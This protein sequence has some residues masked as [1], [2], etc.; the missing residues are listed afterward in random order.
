MPEQ[1]LQH[2]QQK[3]FSFCKL[4]QSASNT[5]PLSSCI[6]TVSWDTYS[7]Q[8]GC[9]IHNFYGLCEIEAGLADL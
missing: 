4:S 9:V 2:N 7:M 8:T 5:V 6:I 3:V 1:E